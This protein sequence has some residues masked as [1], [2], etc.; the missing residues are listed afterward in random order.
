MGRDANASHSL[1]AGSCRGFDERYRVLDRPCNGISAA[2]A[3]DSAFKVLLLRRL[4]AGAGFHFNTNEATARADEPENIGRP[5]QAERD[6][7]VRVDR[8]ADA[9]GV[10]PDDDVVP[11]REL[12]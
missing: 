11:A 2:D 6:H 1:P 7:A 5:W 12:D 4:A 8:A 3:L 10:F 9:D